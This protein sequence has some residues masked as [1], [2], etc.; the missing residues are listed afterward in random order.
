MIDC[1]WLVDNS[2]EKY[3]SLTNRHTSVVV[4]TTCT[5]QRACKHAFFLVSAIEAKCQE[6]FNH[7]PTYCTV[8]AC[9]WQQRKHIDLL[10]GCGGYHYCNFIRTYLDLRNSPLFIRMQPV[11]KKRSGLLAESVRKQWAARLPPPL[12]HQS[13][14]D[15]HGV[16]STLLNTPDEICNLGGPP[17]VMFLKN[18]NWK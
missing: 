16:S 17:V 3:W 7:P 13:H 18:Q 15:M 10:S 8:H 9:T 1:W 2:G 12:P 4:N 14:H 5:M 6:S 11:V